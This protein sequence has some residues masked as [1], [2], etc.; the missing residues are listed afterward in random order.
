MAI[1][2][3]NSYGNQL[4]SDIFYSN[5]K[6]SQLFILKSDFVSFCKERM[7]FKLNYFFIFP[8]VKF[9]IFHR[10]GIV[11]RIWRKILQSRERERFSGF[12]SPTGYHSRHNSSED[13]HS[14]PNDQEIFRLLD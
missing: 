13:F 6:Q 7:N 11:C 1:W 2:I 9:V 10:G 8:P 3:E 5:F 4:E 14:M 12:S